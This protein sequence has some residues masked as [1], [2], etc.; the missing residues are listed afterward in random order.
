[1]KAI[2]LGVLCGL[3]AL[4]AAEP[5]KHLS[6]QAT[7]TRASLIP[8]FRHGYLVLFP[9]GAFPGVPHSAIAYGFTAY[10]PDGQFAYQEIVQLPGGRDPVVQCGRRHRQQ[11]P[12][13][14][15]KTPHLE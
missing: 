13:S 2:L 14:V 7:P 9:G 6:T 15:P 10:G 1:M 4:R 8:L 11:P 5:A 12:S 3:T